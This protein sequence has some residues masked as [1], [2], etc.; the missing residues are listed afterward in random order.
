MKSNKSLEFLLADSRSLE[1][2][3]LPQDMCQ[4]QTCIFPSQPIKHTKFN[5]LIVSKDN[6]I[7]LCK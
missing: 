4:K 2:S 7:I 6:K 1:Q 3:Q 5:R